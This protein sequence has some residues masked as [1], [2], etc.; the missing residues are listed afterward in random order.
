MLVNVRVKIKGIIGQHH[1][2]EVRL[3]AKITIVAKIK[4]KQTKK[5]A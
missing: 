5:S 1:K 3:I 2:Q 4:N